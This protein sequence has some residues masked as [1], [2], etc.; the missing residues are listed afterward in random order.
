MGLIEKNSGVTTSDDF[1]T[2][3][4]PSGIVQGV[5]FFGDVDLVNVQLLAVLINNGEKFS[6]DIKF[7]NSGDGKISRNMPEVRVNSWVNG[8]EVK[9]KFARIDI[10]NDDKNEVRKNGP[11]GCHFL[12]DDVVLLGINENNWI[13]ALENKME[14]FQVLVQDFNLDLVTLVKDRGFI[15]VSGVNGDENSFFVLWNF[16]KVFHIL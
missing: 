5:E 13:G 4:E 9:V 12:Y 2:L 1:T 14:R 16:P 11:F 10:I 3:S 7:Q 15:V 6:V 8:K